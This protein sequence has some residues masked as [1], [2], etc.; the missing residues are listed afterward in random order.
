MIIFRLRLLLGWFQGAGLGNVQLG[1]R[2]IHSYEMFIR[3]TLDFVKGKPARMYL[4]R[5]IMTKGVECFFKEHE[6]MVAGLNLRKAIGHEAMLRIRNV[7]ETS[8]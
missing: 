8:N 7:R 6:S 4:K 3:I 5:K 1:V 2:R